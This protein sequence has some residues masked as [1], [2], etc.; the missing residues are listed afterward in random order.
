MPEPSASPTAVFD[1]HGLGSPGIWGIARI[2]VGEGGA[3]GTAPG[4]CRALRQLGGVYTAF[5]S[6]LN[7]RADLLDAAH[8]AALRHLHEVTS[9]IP[10]VSAPDVAS[11]I[12]R[13]LGAAG[14]ELALNMQALPLWSTLTRTAYVSARGSQPVIVQVARPPVSDAE[15]AA[16]EKGLRAVG[17]PDLAAITT[18]A[19]RAEFREWLRNGESLDRERA[20]LDVLGRHQGETLAGYPLPIPELSTSAVLCWPEVQGRSAA[21]LLRQGNAE[22]AALIA[23]AFL[24][25]LYSLSMVDGDPD[26]EAL[27]VDGDNRLHFRRL[28]NPISVLPGT[29]NTGIKYVSAVMEGNASLSGQT[30]IRLMISHP[31]LDLDARL[32]DEFSGIEP[33][34]KINMWFPPSAGAF[35]SNWRALARLPLIRPLFLDCLHRNLIAVGYWNADA[36]RAGAPARDAIA[37]AQW[38]VVS[39]LLR[40][41]FDLLMNRETAKEWAVATGLLAFGGVRSMNRIMEEMRENDLTI[42]VDVTPPPQPQPTGNLVWFAVL[43]AGLLLILLL[44][45]RWAGAAPEPWATALKGVAVFTLAGLFWV[46]S[47][48]G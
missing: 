11:V 33:E 48:M 43:L 40:T 45:F 10:A 23:A 37:E 38:P 36:V 19:V 46:V 2:P 3:E 31:P 17:S 32:I 28:S 14:D 24:E 1:S 7:W 47:K 4:L 30:L 35:E 12:R 16:F 25:Q 34:L 6:F 9:H 5:G 44:C 29:I 13:E 21:E 42:G 41:R 8:V 26:L 27:I 15:F 18:P 20:F 22:T 39:R